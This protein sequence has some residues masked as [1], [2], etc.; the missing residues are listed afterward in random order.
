M[1][2]AQLGSMH[3][4]LSER[5]LG[6]TVSAA[7]IA[8]LAVSPVSAARG[9]VPRSHAHP[10]AGHDMRHDRYASESRNTGGSAVN[11]K[12]VPLTEV[13]VGSN[14]FGVAVNHSTGTVYVADDTGVAV[15]DATACNAQNPTGCARIPVAVRAGNGGIG[16][17]MD[18]STDTVYVA[19]GAD[20]TVSVIDAST[21]NARSQSGCSADHPVVHVGSLPTHLAVDL[22]AHTLYVSNEGAEAPGTTLSMVDTLTCNATV[23][24][25]CQA[26]PP[27]APVGAGPD[28]LSVDPR[29]HTLF[30]SNGADSTVTVIDTTTCN[31][32]A[33]AGCRGNPP[34]VHLASPPIGSALDVATHTLFV[35]TLS[36]AQVPDAPGA[37]SMIDTSTCNSEV[38]TGCSDAPTRVSTGSGPI[39]VAI[40]AATRRAYVVSQEDSYVSVIDIRRCNAARTDGCRESSPAMTIGFDGGAVAVDPT[41]DTIYATSQDEATV[42]VLDGATCNASRRTG[43][44]T[45]A[46]TTVTGLGPAGSALNRTTGTLYV[47]NQLADTVS[48]IDTARC[49]SGNTAGCNQPWPT[50]RVGQ[51]PK[52]VGIDEQLDSAYVANQNSSTVSVIDTRTCN[53]RTSSGCG[54]TPASIAVA[55]GAFTLSTDVHTHTVYVANVNSDTVSVIDGRSCNAHVTSGCDQAPRTVRTGISPAGLLVD[56]ATHTLYVAH[57]GDA[58]VSL[59]D[60]SRCNG[61]VAVGCSDKLPT[62]PITAAPWFMAISPATHTLYVSTRD[63][64]TLAMVDTARCNA[65]TSRGCAATPPVVQVGFLPYGVA[66]DPRSGTVLVGNVGDSTVSAFAGATCNAT[67]DTGCHRTQPVVDTGG[68]PTNLTVDER[69]G[70]LYVSD[71]VDATASILNLRR[72]AP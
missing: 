66:V 35:P 22:A 71:N 56:G 10:K 65:D 45:P 44:R 13:E 19:N 25:G 18:A 11:G 6:G 40:N 21:C 61:S 69:T 47:T 2:D 26:T 9:S 41:T 55:G 24:T 72:L 3:R 48:V 4:R 15:I 37:L 50:V 5:W 7:L 70:T 31:A 8:V 64:S 14:P 51:S 1:S 17:A 58:A 36:L 60:T 23:S 46:P 63:R 67:V 62:V 54:R 33:A 28:G 32:H 34:T 39:D 29:S 57:G 59:L 68:W 30:V 42:S 53:A 12:T 27:T 52:A 49:R 38:L 20:D 16:I 43:C